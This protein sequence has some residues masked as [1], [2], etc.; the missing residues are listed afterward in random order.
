MIVKVSSP[1]FSR[2]PEL[3][4][5]LLDSFPQ[6]VFNEEGKRFGEEEL[7]EY[8][9]DADAAVI[10]LEPLTRRVLDALPRLRVISKYGVGLDNLDADHAR[11]LG[12]H[13]ACTPGVN[14]RS[15]AEQTLGFLIGLFRNLFLG[16][17]RIKSGEWRKEGGRTLTGRTVGIVGCGHIGTEVLRL[18]KVFECRLLICDILDK[19][20]VARE[21]GAAQVSL[22]ELLEASEAVSLHVPL[23]EETNGMIGS[24]ALAMMRRDAYLVNTSR[25]QVVD[26]AA[27]KEALSKGA[28]AGAAL[29]VFVQE[30]PT[31]A[32][33]LS[34]PNLTVT[35]H[36]GANAREAVEAMGMAA[37]DGLVHFFQE[38]RR[39][40]SAAEKQ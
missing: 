30:P 36:I 13:V 1:S 29:D 18:L 6:A 23:T 40:A 17:R 3:R 19:T 26:Q 24:S 12:K 28:I 8:L 31:D 25:G 10:G 5:H 4:R 9:R 20:D 2:H 16:D 27:L 37:I 14:R 39:K 15:V 21:F 7:A 34:L 38:D 32:E 22:E 33:F 11:L 35:P